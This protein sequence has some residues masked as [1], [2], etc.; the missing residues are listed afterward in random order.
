MNDE[1]VWENLLQMVGESCLASARRAAA[2]KNSTR[3]RLDISPK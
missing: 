2:M 1:A 3:V